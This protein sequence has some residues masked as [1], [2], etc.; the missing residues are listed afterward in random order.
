MTH[1][2]S[3]SLERAASHSNGNAL[4]RQVLNGDLLA[5][6]KEHFE[7]DNKTLFWDVSIP[8][9]QSGRPV[10]DRNNIDPSVLSKY[11]GNLGIATD[12][13]GGLS[14]S[15]GGFYRS[16]YNPEPVSVGLPVIGESTGVFA[17]QDEPETFSGLEFHLD[18]SGHITFSAT[19]TEGAA[20]PV[21]DGSNPS[22]PDYEHMVNF[23]KR[24]LIIPFHEGKREPIVPAVSMHP[25]NA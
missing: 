2:G 18:A 12:E 23:A 19:D 15:L 13:Q 14:L 9:D 24:M 21:F 4:S 22:D 20:T 17:P 16:R 3:L 7:V 6:I 8:L 1:S 5:R 10:I 11:R 25:I